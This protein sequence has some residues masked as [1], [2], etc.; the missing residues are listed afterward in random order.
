MEGLARYLSQ[1]KSK[2]FKEFARLV[3]KGASFKNT[4][5]SAMGGTRSTAKGSLGSTNLG[6]L[7]MIRK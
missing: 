4:G 5:S 3:G 7:R 2:A 6:K 1:D